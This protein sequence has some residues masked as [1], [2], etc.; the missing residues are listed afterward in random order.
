MTRADG[1][2]AR[3]MQPTSSAMRALR[4]LRLRMTAWYV[5]T[6]ALILVTL[7]ALLFAAL[8]HDVSVELDSS[9]RA[10]TKEI[11][12]ATERRER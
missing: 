11:A 5:G 7:G 1:P 2:G 10:A 4:R 12:H 3:A 8:A 9:L 6:F